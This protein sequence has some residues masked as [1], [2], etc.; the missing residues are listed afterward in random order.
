MDWENNGSLIRVQEYTP[1]K[2]ALKYFADFLTNERHSWANLI[3]SEN[4][5]NQ[6]CLCKLDSQYRLFQSS[7]FG[8][9]FG[10]CIYTQ[11]PLKIE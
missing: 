2:N 4:I 9:F 11:T 3:S 10:Q 7:K 5:R 1:C 8:G 6:Y